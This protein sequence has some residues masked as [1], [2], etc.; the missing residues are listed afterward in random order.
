MQEMNMAPGLAYRFETKT[1][2]NLNYFTS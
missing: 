1:R 2:E